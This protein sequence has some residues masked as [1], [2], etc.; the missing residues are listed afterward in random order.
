M[1]PT[2]VPGRHAHAHGVVPLVIADLWLL[3]PADGWLGIEPAAGNQQVVGQGRREVSWPVRFHRLV[4]HIVVGGVQ[5]PGPGG[6]RECLYPFMVDRQVPVGDGRR[7][8][9]LMVG[10]FVQG[11]AD[12]GCGRR[13]VGDPGH[14]LPVHHPAN[15]VRGNGMGTHFIKQRRSWSCHVNQCQ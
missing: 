5:H 4:S 10:Q 9:P 11:V 12:H 8:L 7:Q 6:T 13:P 2:V 14:Q 15:G 1:P 3:G